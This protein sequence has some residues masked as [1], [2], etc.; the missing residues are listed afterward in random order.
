MAEMLAEL[1]SYSMITLT[2]DGAGETVSMHRL[3]QAVTLADLAPDQQ[4]AIREE[5]GHIAGHRTP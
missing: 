5:A 4:I 2:S 3:V 1:A